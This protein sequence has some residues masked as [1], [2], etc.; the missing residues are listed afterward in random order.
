MHRA[1]FE[2]EQEKIQQS[3]SESE[4][5]QEKLLQDRGVMVR[6]RKADPSSDKKGGR[7][8]AAQGR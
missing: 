6:S 7:V 2:M 5:I 3:I 4:L 1:E 8:R